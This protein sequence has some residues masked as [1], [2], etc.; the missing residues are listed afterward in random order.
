MTFTLAIKGL[1][2]LSNII[3]LLSRGYDLFT[4]LWIDKKIGDIDKMK[5]NKASKRRA[6]LK[7]IKEC[8]NDEQRKQLSIILS[9]INNSV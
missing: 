1:I 9:D 4:D 2:A 8:T 3:P 7:S 6:L 5:A